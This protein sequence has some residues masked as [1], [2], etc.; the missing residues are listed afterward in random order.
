MNL[1][2][3]AAIMLLLVCLTV[4]LIADVEEERKWRR[5]DTYIREH[6]HEDR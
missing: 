1:A 2:L 6:R 3:L 4:I 5:I